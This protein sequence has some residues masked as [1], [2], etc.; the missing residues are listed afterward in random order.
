MWVR[1]LPE[2]DERSSGMCVE[3]ASAVLADPGEYQRAREKLALM[4]LFWR[5]IR[6]RGAKVDMTWGVGGRERPRLG[7]LARSEDAAISLSL[8][9]RD[10]PQSVEEVGLALD[11][12]PVEVEW[13]RP[14]PREGGETYDRAPVGDIF[15]ADKRYRAEIRAQPDEKRHHVVVYIKGRPEHSCFFEWPR[16]HQP[17]G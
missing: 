2:R 15:E 14:E 9:L 8:L 13:W 1:E 5:A 10:G 12:E 16:R 11:G 7:V 6:L 17:G 3:R 4:G